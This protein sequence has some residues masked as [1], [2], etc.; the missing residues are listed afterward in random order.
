MP[1]FTLIEMLVSLGIITVIMAVIL[2]GQTNFSRT[3]VLTDTAYTIAV[4]IRQMESYGIS[5]LTYT[6][7]NVTTTNAGY[8]VHF[9]STMPK[10]YYEIADVNKVAGSQTNNNNPP[11]GWCPTGTANTPEYKPG[12]CIYDNSTEQLAT[13]NLKTGYYIKQ[14]CGVIAN[15]N[16]STLYCTGPTTPGTLDITFVRPNTQSILIGYSPLTGFYHLSSACIFLSSPD[17]STS[18][19]IRVSNLGEVEVKNTNTCT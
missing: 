3:L 1:A 4:T 7:N 14:L 9:D 16:S 2:L 5:S 15:G 11:N 13:V 10:S 19:M 8:G 18:R 6:H 12:N 17:G